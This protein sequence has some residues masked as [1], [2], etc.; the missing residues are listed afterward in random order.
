M[1]GCCSR[2]VVCHRKSES[3]DLRCHEH[4]VSIGAEELQFFHD[5]PRLERSSN[6]FIRISM[7][8]VILVVERCTERNL[9]VLADLAA[10]RL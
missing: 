9:Q 2:Y 4:V 10:G 6:V 1:D 3:T 5:E 8:K 7:S